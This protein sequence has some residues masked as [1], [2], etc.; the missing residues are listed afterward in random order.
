LRASALSYCVDD[1]TILRPL[2]LE[3]QRG[4]FLALIGPNGSGKSTLLRCLA[5]ILTAGGGTVTVDGHD[6]ATD[7]LAAKRRIGYAVD[8]WALPGELSGRQCLQLFA[9]AR[10]LSAVPA[11]TWELAESL[12]CQQWIDCPVGDCSLGT[13]QKFGLL[14][15]LMDTPPL[16]LLDEPLNGLD[17]LSAYALKQWLV[18]VTG[19]GRSA[20][21]LATHAL[22]VAER[23]VNRAALLVDGSWLQTWSLNDLHALRNSPDDSLELSMVAALRGSMAA[24]SPAKA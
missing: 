16:L 14:L 20:V 10:E 24:A 23:Y 6:L 7:P 21:L 18:Q 13:R 4:D 1:R 5:G 15:G 12:G 9:D 8:P 11:E 2:D 22:E 3:L 17:P 19:S